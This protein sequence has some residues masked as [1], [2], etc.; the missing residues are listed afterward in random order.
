MAQVRNITND[1]LV[2]PELG[3]LGQTVAAG[4]VVTIPDDRLD[5]FTCQPTIW[6][7]ATAS[8]TKRGSRANLDKE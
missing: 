5:G 1:D 3:F 2:V 6:E 8:P 7:D 4:A